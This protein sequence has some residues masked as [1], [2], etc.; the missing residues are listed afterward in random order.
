MEH[1]SELVRIECYSKPDIIV[2]FL[3]GHLSQLAVCACH[4][5]YEFQL[6]KQTSFLSGNA[7]QV[8]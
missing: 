2:T 8:E 1:L 7:K 5:T 6:R 3:V 4:Q